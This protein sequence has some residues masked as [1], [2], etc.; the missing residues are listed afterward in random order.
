MAEQPRLPTV[1]RWL[2]PGVF[3]LLGLICGSSFLWIHRIGATLTIRVT[4]GIGV[5]S[6]RYDAAVSRVA[7]RGRG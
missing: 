7:N 5:V 6:L 1:S 3:I 2:T 4:L